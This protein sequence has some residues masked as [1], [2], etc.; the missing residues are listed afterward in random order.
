MPLCVGDKLAPGEILAPIGVSGM[1]E[2]YRAR[3]PRTGREVDIKVSAECFSDR[4]EREVRAVAVLN[5]PTSAASTTVIYS[6]LA[7]TSPPSVGSGSFS[8]ALV[9][10]IFAW[11]QLTRHDRQ[12]NCR[13][14]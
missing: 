12:E 11:I 4:F 10:V 2:V 13:P 5:H 8:T 7:A 3:D 9:P 14:K 1:G 6:Q